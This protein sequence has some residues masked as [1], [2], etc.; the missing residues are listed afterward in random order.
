LSCR[1]CG[2]GQQRRNR[3]RNHQGFSHLIFFQFI[4]KLMPTNVGYGA[5]GPGGLKFRFYLELGSGLA[6]ISEKQA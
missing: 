2:R 4:L 1:N 6:D 5:N 3:H